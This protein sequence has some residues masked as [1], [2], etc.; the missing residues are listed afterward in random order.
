MLSARQDE[1]HGTRG[2]RHMALIDSA[3][4]IVYGLGENSGSPCVLY[5]FDEAIVI[6]HFTLTA[7]QQWLS[8]RIEKSSAFQE[9][10]S[11]PK[12]SVTIDDVVSRSA[13]VWVFRIGDIAKATL[14]KSKFVGVF[15]GIS[16]LNIDWTQNKVPPFYVGRD[17][18]EAVA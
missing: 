3:T 18:T 16:V 2:R 14:K 4:G 13:R 17:A 12:A 6:A 15:R 8:N 1:R 9:L 11:L 5:S 10:D 7:K